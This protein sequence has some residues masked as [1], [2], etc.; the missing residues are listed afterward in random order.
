MAKAANRK[1]L[2]GSVKRKAVAAPRKTTSPD[3]W[4]Q[5]GPVTANYSPLSPIVFLPRAAE[6]FPDRVASIHG[7]AR[8]TY[9]Q[10]YARARR[11]ASALA[12]RGVRRGDVVSAMLPNVPAMLEAHYGV[13]MAGAVL[14]TINTRL[15]ADTVAY[16]LSHGEAKVLIT[17]RVFASVVGPALAS[18]NKKPLVVDVD[19]ALYTGP[20]DRLGSIEYEAFLAK[21]DPNFRWSLPAAETDPIALNYT[22]G[23][24]GR[25]KGVVYHHRGTFLEACGNVMAWAMPARPVYLWT[26]PMFHCN[27]WCF[28]W[29]VTAM[30]GTHVCLR[31]VDPQQIFA[32]IVEHG[33]THMCGAPTVLTMLISAPEEHRR[34]FEQT[35]HIQTGGSPPPAKVIKGMEE[36]GFKVLHIYGMTE[37][38]GPSTFCAEQDAW[39]GM[40]MEARANEMAR[41]G[42]R[43]PVVEGHIVGD[44]RTCRPVPQDGKTVGEILV[45][46]NTVML[47]YLKDPKATAEA[48]AGGWMHTGDLAVWHPS[49][50]VEIRDRKKDIIISGGENISSVEV[51]IALYRHPATALAAVVARPD[52]K[53]GETPCAFVQLKP[54]ASATEEEYIQ[55]CR[56]NLA[57]FK[58]PKKVVFGAVPTTA[59][60]KIQKYVLRERAKTL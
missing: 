29:S 46:G 59:T 4:A 19:D 39:D 15:D 1:S 45:Q 44:P 18:L 57:R 11:L 58:V 21:G 36:L 37:L 5:L 40:P 24:T 48:F 56:D 8:Y 47:G 60:G 42:V 28:P 30:G 10:L 52:E 3:L 22:S 20:G 38:Q 17:D 50:Y 6:I 16:I 54:G 14:N 25:P 53:W 7:N 41:Q 13:P 23:T 55:W 43:Y 51:E 33:V 49:N 26:L 34:R 27:G 35:V 12:R 9:A 32:M 2:R 31:A